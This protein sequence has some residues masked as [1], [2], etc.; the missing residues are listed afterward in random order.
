MK[1]MNMF[2]EKDE[3]VFEGAENSIKTHGLL[4]PAFIELTLNKQETRVC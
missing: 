2:S 1:N 4:Y 3:H